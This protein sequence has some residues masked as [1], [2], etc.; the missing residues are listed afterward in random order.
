MCQLLVQIAWL[1]GSVN[2]PK[3]HAQSKKRS[4]ASG[5]GGVR[6]GGWGEGHCQEDIDSYLIPI[7]HV[8][9][10]LLCNA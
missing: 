4:G 1:K 3:A 5:V 7:Q 8:A 9:L 6:F 10:A 2:A